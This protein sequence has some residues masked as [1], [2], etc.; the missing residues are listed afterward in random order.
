MQ[1]NDLLDRQLESWNTGDP[2]SI[3]NLLADSPNAV[4]RDD[5]VVDLIYAEV[6]LRES[7]GEHPESIEYV[8]RFPDYRE[9][10]EK[11]FQVHAALNSGVDQSNLSTKAD[12]RTVG[13]D[14]HRTTAPPATL[15][16]FELEHRLGLGGSGVAWRARET[17]LDRVVAIKFLLDG[18]DP[19]GTQRLVHEAAAAAK[20]VHP[21]IVQVFQVGQAKDVPYLVMEYVDGGTLAEKLSSGPLPIDDAVSLTTKIGQAIQHAHDHSVIHRD[22]KPGNILLAANG[23]PQVCDFGLA[24]KLDAEQSLHHTGDIIGTPAYMPPE[25]A[26]GERGDERSDV[27]SLGAVLYELLGGRSPFQAAHPWEILYLVNSADPVPLRQLNPALPADLETICQK[28]LEKNPDR[29][30]LSAQELVEDLQRFSEHKPILARPVGSLQKFAKWCRRNRLVASLVAASLLL[31]TTLA[32]GSTIVA[33][34]LSASNRQVIAQRKAAQQASEQAVADRSLAVDSLNELVA[35][36]DEDLK[37]AGIPIYIKERLAKKAIAGLRKVSEI[38]GDARALHASIV[39]KMQIADLQ[40]QRGKNK[41]AVEDAREAVEEARLYVALHPHADDQP[42]LAKALQYLATIY[43]FHFRH[44]E[45]KI[46]NDEATELLGQF[47]EKDPDN[48]SLLRR[49]L[50][51]V[52]LNID[53]LWLQQPPAQVAVN[54]ARSAETAARLYK[55]GSDDPEALSTVSAFY[56]GL[57]RSYLE[58]NQ[59]KLAGKY[60]ELALASI[61]DAL[62]IDPN[63][64]EYQTSAGIAE[65]MLGTLEFRRIHFGKSQLF[66]ESARRRFET[67][68]Q[69]DPANTRYSQ[70]VANIAA[71]SIGPS[72]AMGNIDQSRKSLDHCLEINRRLLAIAPGSLDQR[73]QIANALALKLDIHTRSNEWKQAIDDCQELITLLDGQGDEQPLSMTVVPLF[74]LS[75]QVV[76]DAAKVQLGQP[77]SIEDVNSRY[78]AMFTV[79]RQF[80]LRN[81]ANELDESALAQLALIDEDLEV[82]TATEL[83]EYLSGLAE[84]HPIFK[85]QELLYRARFF[86]IQA[87]RLDRENEKS[88]SVEERIRELT[89]QAIVSLKQ[90]ANMSPVALNM[91]YVEPELKWLRKQPA[92]T[93]AGLV[94]QGADDDGIEVNSTAD[95]PRP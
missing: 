17:K 76:T 87:Q 83:M 16:G 74:K 66:F 18:N 31:L 32:I 14:E 8:D 23:N 19:R 65:R 50:H 20:L 42:I 37:H 69:S 79:A 5:V 38:E 27:Y 43:S 46:V 71:M 7:Q 51:S 94:I 60:L 59:L 3:E 72:S 92:F 36:I 41:E 39:A 86:S 24:R 15:P 88:D 56:G 22:L 90:F 11:Q 61:N 44:E 1:L 81:S 40:S 9:L 84:V 34:E 53:Q 63:S 30:Y 67:L 54:A 55:L 21:S 68:L 25:Q 58:S 89:D 2:I 45:L 4:E 73:S 85:Q 70:N 28:C 82:V 93:A 33:F 49:Q 35:T 12:H 13:F 10:I 57:G 91:I 52:N 29:R 48:V 77:V 64:N 6:L 80:A 26:R 62:E 95:D 47:L 78:I 75:A